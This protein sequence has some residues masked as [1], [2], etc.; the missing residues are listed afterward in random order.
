MNLHAQEAIIR[1][2]K[3]SQMARAETALRTHIRKC[4]SMFESFS[5]S[6]M[7]VIR[8]IDNMGRHFRGR[9][10]PYFHTATNIE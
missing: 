2:I 7:V 5:P 4:I 9:S 8:F 1:R 10:V 6:E 3:M